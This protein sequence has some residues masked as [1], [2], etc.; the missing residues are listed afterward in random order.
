MEHVSDPRSLFKE[1][2]KIIKPNGRIYLI[3]PLIRRQ[4]QAPYDY[5]RFTEYSLQMLCEYDFGGSEYCQF[6]WIYGSYRLLLFF[7]E[8]TWPTFSIRTLA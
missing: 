7:P 6:W 5:F 4:H 8:G 3:A 1:F 2:R